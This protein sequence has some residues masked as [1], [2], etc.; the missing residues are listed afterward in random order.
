ML[1]KSSI[2]KNP[3]VLSNRFGSTQGC[4]SYTMANGDECNRNYYCH[5]YDGNSCVDANLFWWEV[6]GGTVIAGTVGGVI[7]AT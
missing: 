3:T 4:N 1:Q 2:F 7:I 5:F 6:A